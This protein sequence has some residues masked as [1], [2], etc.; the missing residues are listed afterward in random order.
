MAQ[1]VIKA[2]KAYAGL[3]LRLGL[4][5][6]FTFYGLQKLF[7]YSAVTSGLLESFEGVFQPFFIVQVFIYCLPFIE[8]ILGLGLITGYKHRLFYFLTGLLIIFLILGKQIQHDPVTVGRN[9]I[10]LLAIV[11]GLYNSEN[12]IFRAGRDY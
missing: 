2:G 12:D 3:L 6:I 1:D 11:F 5:V 7:S 9:L 4:G 10:F 8:L